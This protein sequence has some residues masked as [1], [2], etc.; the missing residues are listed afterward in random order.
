MNDQE[1]AGSNSAGTVGIQAGGDVHDSTVYIVGPEDPP[2]KRY[3][4]GV[5]HLKDGIPARA[6]Q[7]IAEAIAHGYDSGEVRFHWVLALLSKRAYRDLTGEEQEQLGRTEAILGA[8][9][10]DG[11]KRAL[12][13]IYELLG[14]LR[15]RQSD[16]GSVMEKVSSLDTVPREMIIHHLD[17]FLSGSA[18]D[19]FWI[20]T[21]RGAIENRYAGDRKGRVW[22]YFQPEPMPPRVRAPVPDTTTRRDRVLVAFWSVLL[23]TGAGHLGWIV[24]SHTTPLAIAALLMA[25]PAGYVGIRTALD[26]RYR[27]K[28]L[29]V[30]DVE[31]LGQ[32]GVN[33]APEGGFANSVDHSFDHYF[34]KYPPRGVNSEEWLAATSG[35]RQSMRDEIAELYRESRIGVGRVKWLIR[36]L[37][38]EV[39][40]RWTRGDLWR[41]RERY[42]VAPR[43]K[44]WCVVSLCVLVGAT[45]TV[46]VSAVRAA[47]VPAVLTIPLVLLSG[48]KATGGWF[49]LV[50]ERRRAIEDRREYEEKSQDRNRE[51]NRW[52][53]RLRDTRPS[54][55][56]ME[57]W[58]NCDITVL[59]DEMLE[60]YRLAWRDVLAHAVLRTPAK[61][62]QKARV[63]RGFWRYSRYDLRLFLI[64]Q[65]GVRELS[66]QLDFREVSF[67]GQERNNYRFDAVSSVY[68]VKRSEYSHELRLTL[69]NGPSREIHATDLEVPQAEPGEDSS[70]FATINL[71]SAG[72]M[73]TLRIL[74]GIA[75]EGKGWIET[76]AA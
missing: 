32:R 73:H 10:D 28:R 39:A 7:L 26:W 70:M 44:V 64:T 24:V 20:E 14:C 19:G 34:G 76:D 41:Y 63:S 57:T 65:D 15:D 74:E 40:Q 67:G 54:E 62:S 42:H 30:K 48:F 5:R 75:A 29:R 60:H 50:Y 1:T 56:E 18:R 31:Y 27:S 58:L 66:T 17:H 9:R 8:F 12:E 61:G 55:N 68:V 13:V 16:P 35:I 45:L 25:P 51:Y 4:V 37:A 43:V 71:D 69:T 47:L 33:R 36:Y 72:F 2:G 52:R 53:Q 6:R 11:W 59:L 23:A 3:A 49:D 21:R 46:M 22:S 38:R